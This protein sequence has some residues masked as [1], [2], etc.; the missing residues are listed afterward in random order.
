MLKEKRNRNSRK[1]I[2][3][4]GFDQH[5][6]SNSS[7]KSC[8][9]AHLASQMGK[10]PRQ[11]NPGWDF[12]R[13]QF[14]VPAYKLRMQTDIINLWP[15]YKPGFMLMLFVLSCKTWNV[16]KPGPWL[17]QQ[18]NNLKIPSPSYLQVLHSQQQPLPVR[19][20]SRQVR[21]KVRGLLCFVSEA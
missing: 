12:K 18:F 14:G 4:L 6:D 20:V 17:P 11:C 13:L 5:P 2:T 15:N 10:G 1:R 9:T 8:V 21:S 7:G 19:A 3:K 16:I